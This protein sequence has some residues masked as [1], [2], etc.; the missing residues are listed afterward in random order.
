M[1]KCVSILEIVCPFQSPISLTRLFF[2]RVTRRSTN[3]RRLVVF[4]SLKGS[5][6]SVRTARPLQLWRPSPPPFLLPALALIYLMSSMIMGSFYDCRLFALS[7]TSFPDFR[8][9]CRKKRREKN[10]RRVKHFVLVLV[11]SFASIHTV[12]CFRKFF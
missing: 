2:R 10:T 1:G 4:S 3:S 8:P 12:N 5:G 9:S 7:L 6:K 11:T